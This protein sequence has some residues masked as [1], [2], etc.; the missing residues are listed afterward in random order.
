MSAVMTM[1]AAAAGS[2]SSAASSSER[3]KA[4]AAPFSS[5]AFTRAESIGS[6]T[7]PSAMPITESGNW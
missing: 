4:R 1:N 2:A 6:R 7:T 3:F 5:P